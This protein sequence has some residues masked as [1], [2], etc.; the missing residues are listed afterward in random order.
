MR[1]WR[2][3]EFV[4]VAVF[5]AVCAGQGIVL[6][7]P[8]GTVEPSAPAAHEAA[9]SP[10]P[11][12]PLDIA[13]SGSNL[14]LVERVV[15]AWRAEEPGLRARVH[16]S[17]GSGGAIRALRDG[18]IEVGLVS[19][20]LR[21][22]E[23][24]GLEVDWYAEVPVVVACHPAAPVESL[25]AAR[26]QSIV[27]GREQRWP[28]GSPI[29]FVA[30]EPSDSSLLAAAARDP[31]LGDALRAAFASGRFP[32]AYS[33]AALLDALERIPGSLGV[34]D[35][36]QVRLRGTLRVLAELGTKPL[37][38]ATRGTPRGAAARLL[39]RLRHRETRVVAEA[40]GYRVLP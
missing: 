34:T 1:R 2:T 25:D 22:E 23:A 37:G 27:E 32:T 24:D 31:A 38:A 5:L 28:D 36:G 15:A 17:I 16:P 14:P 13:G 19:R 21:P 10:S 18:A 9:A 8:G 4:A 40:A 30:R 20:P 26:L 29:V 3:A 39:E 35:L 12:V 33:D 11:D 7:W 6:A